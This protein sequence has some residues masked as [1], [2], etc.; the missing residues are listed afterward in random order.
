MFGKIVQDVRAQRQRLRRP[1][2]FDMIFDLLDERADRDICHS[3]YY[4]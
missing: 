3:L 1:I 2:G 4:H